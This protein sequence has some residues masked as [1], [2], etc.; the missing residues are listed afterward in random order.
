[1]DIAK[2]DENID[3]WNELPAS[4]TMT[5]LLGAK[6]EI[7]WYMGVDGQTDPTVSTFGEIQS[8]ISNNRNKVAQANANNPRKSLVVI[9]KPTKASSYK[10][11]V[12]IMDELN[13]AK[14]I[15]APA[16]DDDHF[17][18]GETRFLKAHKMI[19]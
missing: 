5:I 16:I 19:K 15:S 3:A 14:L 4:R 13:I 12:D 8:H 1:M 10:N 17:S 6:N 2:P 9:I 18:V 11:F 7:A